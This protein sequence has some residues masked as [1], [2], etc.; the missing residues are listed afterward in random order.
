MSL[1]SSF[2]PKSRKHSTPNYWCCV[3]GHMPVEHKSSFELE[4]SQFVPFTTTTSPLQHLNIPRR[5]PSSLS[6]ILSSVPI[7]NYTILTD[8]MFFLLFLS[9]FVTFL[10][11]ATLTGYYADIGDIESAN[12]Y[13]RVHQ[14]VWFS[15]GLLYVTVMVGAWCRFINVVW[16]GI[17]G[18]RGENVNM[19]EGTRDRGR[20]VRMKLLQLRS[21][22]WNLS[23]PILAQLIIALIQLPACLLYGLYHHNK[24]IYYREI[25][26][27][28]FF[29]WNLLVPVVI[30]V[31]QLVMIYHIMVTPKRSSSSPKYSPFL[32]QH[33]FPPSM[34]NL[35]FG[36]SLASH[37]DS[38][39]VKFPEKQRIPVH[40]YSYKNNDSSMTPN[41]TQELDPIPTMMPRP[42]QRSFTSPWIP[43]STHF[44]VNKRHD[45]DPEYTLYHQRKRLDDTFTVSSQNDANNNP[46]TYDYYFDS[47]GYVRRS[48]N[49]GVRSSWTENFDSD[50]NNH[51]I[52]EDAI[53]KCEESDVR[54]FGEGSGSGD[55][56]IIGKRVD[57]VFKHYNSNTAVTS[58][59]VSHLS[60]PAT[61]SSTMPLSL[62]PTAILSPIFPKSLSSS[63]DI[64]SIIPTLPSDTTST[65]S[66]TLN[67]SPNKLK[68]PFSS[69][70]NNIKSPKYFRR[71]SDSL[72]IRSR[73]QE[74]GK[75]RN[76]DYSP[77]MSFNSALHESNVVRGT[78]FSPE[79]LDDVISIDE[80]KPPNSENGSSITGIDAPMNQHNQK[81]TRSFLRGH[82]RS[83]SSSGGGAGGVTSIRS[84]TEGKG[85]FND[86]DRN[87]YSG[88]LREVTK[89]I[90][91]GFTGG[92]SIRQHI[93]YP[94]HQRS[95]SSGTIAKGVT[96]L[97]ANEANR[98]RSVTL[99]ESETVRNLRYPMHQKSSSSPE[100][101]LSNLYQD[102]RDNGE[103]T[104]GGGGDRTRNENLGADDL[105]NMRREWLLKKPAPAIPRPQRTDSY[106]D[107]KDSI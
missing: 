39:D 73:R 103:G 72:L 88:G 62:S 16:D 102:G 63:A 18:M 78:S 21:G 69:L 82:R 101:I 91:S 68:S 29:I 106:R 43:H 77:E 2:R 32:V 92:V 54:S 36:D 1:F 22:S 89:S 40:D 65:P 67:S 90:A 46:S 26:L 4:A 25:N 95:L 45:S 74:K 71:Q 85:S 104:S 37:F 47:G 14:L 84:S 70:V 8:I 81:S 96:N 20:E 61:S 83:T 41:Q 64:T 100:N 13:F 76:D 93:R 31:T 50:D 9:P 17:E 66:P 19:T 35:N 49:K 53:E 27:L 56:E 99:P 58:T 86:L 34:Q 97:T 80:M 48:F 107:Y 59:H 79:Y 15:W 6:S 55:G 5:Q 98:K 3:R 24:T 12:S 57:S 94:F 51:Y 33:H 105:S 7:T 23:L 44:S 52:I 30:N 11:L 60:L 42:P 75:R 28:Y 38:E 10:T 87:V